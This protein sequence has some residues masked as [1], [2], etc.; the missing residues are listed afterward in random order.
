MALTIL[1]NSKNWANAWV[2]LVAYGFGW[3][4]GIQDLLENSEL[5]N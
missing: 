3:L 2:S 1:I 4:W 5:E